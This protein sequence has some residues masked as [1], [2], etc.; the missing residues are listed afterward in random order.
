MSLK[1]LSLLG[2]VNVLLRHRRMIMGVAVVS[3][4]AAPAM[5]L[6]RGRDYVA[7]SKFMPSAES[8]S[9]LS[10]G[11]RGALAGLIGRGGSSE[12]PEFYAALINSQ[13]L[14][15]EAASSH[16]PTVRDGDTIM[17]GLAELFE[18]DRESETARTRAA[19]SELAR[20][21]TA[22]PDRAT[23]IITVRTQAPTAIAAVAINQRLVELV[24]EFNS[25]KR[26]YQTTEER[27][28]LEAR[29]E[30]AGEAL[31]LAEV[32]L[33]V[34]LEQNRQ[35]ESSPQLTLER[36]RLQRRVD[37]QQE[38]FLGLEVS[39]Q[40]ARIMEVRDAALVTVVEYPE[41]TLRRRGVGLVR[42]GALGLFLGLLMGIT[43]AFSREGL[44]LEPAEHPDDYEEFR[45][46]SS[47]TVSLRGFF[48]GPGNGRRSELAAPRSVSDGEGSRPP[49]L[50]R[51]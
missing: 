22:I 5:S 33:A 20:R 26:R 21:V 34:F 42:N 23:R 24:E 43:I 48:K 16:Y 4:L 17:V 47:V 1:G 7:E 45:R 32:E 18:I 36:A 46:L 9:D 35:S 30:E 39:L 19:G 11:A 31:E 38:L 44:K 3:G 40:Q 29:R 14:L 8:D 25:E 41:D 49:A 6:L 13:T 15:N 12:S 50:R 37:I 2:Y 10:V 27:R 51:E 28:F